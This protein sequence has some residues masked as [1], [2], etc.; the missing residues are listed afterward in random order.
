MQD[1]N[2]LI[3][4]ARGK[5]IILLGPPGSGKGARAD[6]LKELGL[7]HVST[8]EALRSKIKSEPSSPLAAEVLYFMKQGKLV[9]DNLVVQVVFDYLESDKCL[10]NGFVLD[11]FPRNREQC[12]L[13]L[14]K[15]NIDLAVFLDVPVDFLY[16]GVIGCS[17]TACVECGSGYSRF[18]PPLEEGICSKCGGRLEKRV[19]DTG[20]TI[21]KRI[22]EF[23]KTIS[24]FL[25][26][27]KEKVEVKNLSI[28]VED[29]E[30]IDDTFLKKL[31][32]DVYRTNDN[33]RMLRM[34]NNKGMKQRL[35]QL[36]DDCFEAQL[37]D[38]SLQALDRN[39]PK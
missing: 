31:D 32:S 28:T 26:E 39:F 35:Y 24:T 9:P 38:S 2:K 30:I 29:D 37:R 10:R 3:Q 5:H 21:G 1:K 34:L 16:F 17:R 11:G 22:N 25:P 13:L 20:E 15:Y 4:L 12:R 36:L 23:E 18:D 6:D 7:V 19:D 14:S 27:L 33:G 8:G